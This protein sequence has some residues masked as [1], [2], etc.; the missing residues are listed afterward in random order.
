M[1]TQHFFGNQGKLICA[2]SN[3]QEIPRP[4]LGCY[5]LV[6]ATLLLRCDRSFIIQA[7]IVLPLSTLLSLHRLPLPGPVEASAVDVRADGHRQADLD[8]VAKE[9]EVR[10]ELGLTIWV[11]R[12]IVNEQHL[13]RWIN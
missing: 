5:R 13:K 9:G 11:V 2:E 6:L 7:P 3:V 1:A 8:A 12:M 4:I 10:V